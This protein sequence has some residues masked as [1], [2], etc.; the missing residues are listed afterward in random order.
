MAALTTRMCRSWTSRMTGGSGVG[1]PDAD[2][3]EPAGVAQGDDAGRS[4]SFRRIKGH[5]QIPQLVAAL[6]RHAHP[7]TAAATE[8]VG[9]AA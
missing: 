9:A 2:V 4:Q 3:V 6:H 8:T 1:S 5:Q 7:E